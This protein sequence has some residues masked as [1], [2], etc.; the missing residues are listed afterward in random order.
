MLLSMASFGRAL[1]ALLLVL[2]T[3]CRPPA[4]PT[5]TRTSESAGVPNGEPIVREGSALGLSYLETCPAD[6]CEEPLPMVVFLHGRGDR[7][8]RLEGVLAEG[9]RD[10]RVIMPQ[11]P[12]PLGRG[13]TWLAVSV[14][15]PER[16]AFATSLGARA[17]ELDRWLETMREQRPT[18]GV[19]I[20]AG[21]SQGAMLAY[22][23]ATRHPESCSLVLPIGG[24]LPEALMPAQRDPDRRYPPIRAMHAIDDPIVPFEP[25]ERA[26]EALRE[27]GFEVELST[28]DHVGHRVTQ[29]MDQL[30]LRYV[31][32]A[33]E[34]QRHRQGSAS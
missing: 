3:A 15:S 5:T 19:P 28:F 2:V 21:F 25:T 18:I 16:E 14:T 31:R 12:E 4:E 9:L 32:T 13:F 1:G 34:E 10:V 26:I 29:E 27:K 11:A 20:V 23:L 17:A 22:A 33:L 8:H 24:F 7:P 30:L 6:R